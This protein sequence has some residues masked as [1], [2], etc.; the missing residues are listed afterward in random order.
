MYVCIT[1][2]GKV[3]DYGSILLSCVYVGQ[4]KM[5]QKITRQQVEVREATHYVHT[6]RQKEPNLTSFLGLIVSSKIK[7]TC[8]HLVVQ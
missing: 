4:V 1:I 2:F 6:H 8:L 3:D 7:P 5:V